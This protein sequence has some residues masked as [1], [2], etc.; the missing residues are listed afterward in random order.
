MSKSIVK[1]LIKSS[2]NPY[3]CDYLRSELHKIEKFYDSGSYLLNGIISGDIY[4]GMPEGRI[5]ELAGDS[6]TGKTLILMSIAISF[7]KSNNKNIFIM[8]DSEYGTSSSEIKTQLTEEQ[9]ENQFVVIPIRTYE[10]LICSSANIVEE[11]KSVVKD[12]SDVTFMI[13]LDSLSGLIPQ[14][15]LDKIIKGDDTKVMNEQHLIKIFFNQIRRPLIE[16]KTAMIF[17]NHLYLDIMNAPNKY[18]PKM[19]RQVSRGGQGVNYT[20]D[21]RLRL[22]KKRLKEDVT[23]KE[24]G[25]KIEVI[26]AKSRFIGTHAK[27]EIDVMFSGGIDKYSGLWSFLEDHELFIKNRLGPKGIEFTI[28]EINWSITTSEIKK[29]KSKS[30]LFTKELLDYINSKFKELYG[31]SG[32]NEESSIINNTEEENDN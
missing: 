23:K 25:I 9:I 6:A 17:C 4:R 8:M 31:L 11:I 24:V 21:I 28:P 18:T 22:F 15:Q 1:S 16:T 29:M 32:L 13:G 19:D 26:P 5:I 7:I 20:S 30:E 2:K 27:I 10:E 14:A 3:T 12:D